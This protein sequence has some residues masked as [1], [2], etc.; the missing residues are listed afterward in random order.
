MF[1]RGKEINIYNLSS[2]FY[3]SWSKTRWSRVLPVAQY[4]FPE[5]LRPVKRK[6]NDFSLE[7]KAHIYT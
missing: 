4:N 6:D 2:H 1:S 7:K 5:V 3:N